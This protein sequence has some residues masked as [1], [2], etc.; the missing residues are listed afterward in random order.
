MFDV[1]FWPRVD[2]GFQPETDITPNSRHHIDCLA[3]TH[4]SLPLDPPQSRMRIRLPMS[5]SI[6]FMDSARRHM[7]ATWSRRERGAGEICVDASLAAVDFYRSC[8]FQELGVGEHLLPSGVAMACVFVRKTLGATTHQNG[9]A[10]LD[11]RRSR[12]QNVNLTMRRVAVPFDFKFAVPATSLCEI[13][14]SRS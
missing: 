8:G 7:I 12:L 3:W 6:R 2:F 4:H 1:R 10:S 14:E 13:S 11:A 5:M 9:E